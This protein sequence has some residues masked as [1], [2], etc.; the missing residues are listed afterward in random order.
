MRL[1]VLSDIHAN[2]D[3]LEAVFSALPPHDAIVFAGDALGYYDCPNEV[4]DCLQSRNVIGVR[5]N[6][7]AY[8]LGTLEPRSKHALVYRSDWSRSV[9]SERNMNGL[10]SLP[11][12][13]QLDCEG[14]KIV[15]RHAS[16]WDEETYLYPDSPLLRDVEVP[17]GETLIVGHTHWPLIHKAGTGMLVNPGSVGQPRDWNPDASFATI[18]TV[19]LDFRI[20]RVPYDVARL[21]SR[22]L[23]QGWPIE[24]VSILSRRKNG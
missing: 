13:R 3:A 1:V 16:P 6:H 18:D 10:A 19:R 15:L 8:V 14:M 17:A 4:C 11:V 24:S 22:L 9:L 20:H 23:A 21:Q 5:G 2:L 12:E 7:D